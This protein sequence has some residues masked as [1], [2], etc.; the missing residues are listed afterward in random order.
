MSDERGIRDFV[1]QLHEEILDR[2]VADEDENAGVI[3]EFKENVFT[4]I[5]IEYLTD[6]GAVGDGEICFFERKTTKGNVKVNGY[7]FDDE[8]GTVDL[9]VSIYRPSTQEW[10]LQ[11]RDLD[12]A[13]ARAH[14]F[15]AL[16]RDGFLGDPDESTEQYGMVRTLVDLDETIKSVRIHCLTNGLVSSRTLQ[17]IKERDFTFVDEVWDARRMFRCVASGLPFENVTVDFAA[18]NGTGIPCLPLGRELGEFQVH[19][20]VFPG[21]VLRDLYEEYGSRLLELNVRSF[22]QARGKVNRGIR[23]TLL[24]EPERFLAYNNGICVTAESVEFAEREDKEVLLQSISGMQIVN[25]GQTVASIHRAS[26][27]DGACLDDVFVQAKITEVAIDRINEIVPYIS[28]YSNSQNKV[29]EADFASNDPYHVEIDRLS[30]TVWNSG[31]QSR[32]FYERARGDYQVEKARAGTTAAQRRQFNERCPTRQRFT[33]TDLAKYLNTWDQKPHV[34]SQGAQKNFVK[35]ME[36][37]ASERGAEFKPDE[38]YFKELVAKAILFKTAQSICRRKKLPAYQANAVTYTIAYLSSRALGRLDLERIWKEQR[39]PDPVTEALENW[40]PVIHAQLV[41]SAGSKNVTEWCKKPECWEHIRKL[42]LEEPEAL[43]E[44]LTNRQPQSTVGAAAR[45]GRT[46]KLTPEQQDSIA[47][48]MKV[49]DATWLAIERAG[50]QTGELNAR[51]AGI[52]HT[53]CG[54]AAGNWQHV[55]SAKQAYRGVE[56]LRI[57][58]EKLGIDPGFDL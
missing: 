38:L 18:F 35:F 31:E 41:K 45:S 26:K 16:A 8:Q 57:A 52:A 1:Q 12:E 6:I 39:V 34:V 22:L 20:A 30:R 19:L 2:A 49:D 27:R 53:L 48:V 14:R 9:F 56:I 17:K 10:N 5:M 3:A 33:K 50:R 40:C 4:Q 55:P 15:F 24:S 47:K 54:Y 29:N 21:S 11:T 44:E 37:I 25:G 51:L 13:F 28:R 7:Y 42:D 46:L 36:R 58:K 43:R 23:H 32:W